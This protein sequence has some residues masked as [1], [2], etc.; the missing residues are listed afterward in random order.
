MLIVYFD[1]LSVSYQQKIDV[2]DGI[3]IFAPK[4]ITN[5]LSKTTAPSGGFY[6]NT[7]TN[8]L[9][10]QTKSGYDRG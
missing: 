1:F 8:A 4:F 10:C 6:F 3:H 5:L 9:L 2:L 7:D